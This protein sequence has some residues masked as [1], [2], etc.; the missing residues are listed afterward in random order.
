MRGLRLWMKVDGG[1]LDGLYMGSRE[2][3]EGWEVQASGDETAGLWFGWQG[4]Q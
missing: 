3:E 2:G 4:E 1:V